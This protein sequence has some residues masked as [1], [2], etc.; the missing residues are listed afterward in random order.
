VCGGGALEGRLPGASPC[1]AGTC[2]CEVPSGRSAPRPH[3][4][5]CSSSSSVRFTSDT[6]ASEERR[7]Q[8]GRSPPLGQ[9]NRP[10]HR[11]AAASSPPRAAIA[12][13]K[14][15]G[16]QAH[17]GWVEFRDSAKNRCN[18]DI[19]PWM[20]RKAASEGPGIIRTAA[21]AAAACRVC[22]ADGWRA[23][24]WVGAF[25]A[26]EGPEAATWT[27]LRRLAPWR[28]GSAGERARSWAILWVWCGE[29]VGDT[30]RCTCCVWGCGGVLGCWREAFAH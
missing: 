9:R 27:Q 7:L 3:Q 29:A 11:P 6:A 30:A 23:R 28:A 13:E 15:R 10:P 16:A 18:T 8:P 25:G 4:S 20:P 22:A 17:P 24:F 26:G 19:Q 2:T 14:R 12:H 5:T 1:A 21:P